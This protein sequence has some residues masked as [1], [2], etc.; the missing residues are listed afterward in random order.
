MVG[1]VINNIVLSLLRKAKAGQEVL[2]Y[3]TEH[4]SKSG[5]PTMGGIGIII[6]LLMCCP[7]FIRNN[8][9]LACLTLLVTLAYG[10][11]GLLDDYIKVKRHQNEGLKPYQKIMMQLSIAIIIA[12]FC[13]RDSIVG[14]TLVLP[15]GHDIDIS[16]WIIPLNIFIFLAV[17][18][19]VNLTDGLDGLASWTTIA[20]MLGTSALIALEIVQAQSAGDT[21]LAIEYGNMLTYCLIMSGALLAFL[22]LNCFPAKVF[23]GD[24]GSL[25]LGASVACVSIYTRMSLFIP[26]MGVMFVVSCASVVIQVT[27]FKATKGNRVFLMAPYHHHLQKKGLSESRISYIYFLITVVMALLLVGLKVL[28]VVI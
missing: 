22:L 13:Y 17:T 12:V 4:Q 26:I 20:Y 7:L 5:T 27:Y 19:G 14:H 16:Y 11:V 15:Y 18:N 6:T 25:A 3:V 21:L 1:I 2:K 9:R 24:V 23:M 8:S 28:E 10:I